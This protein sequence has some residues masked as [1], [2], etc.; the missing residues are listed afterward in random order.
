MSILNAGGV[1]LD[2]RNPLE[3]RYHKTILD[4][5]SGSIN[6]GKSAR[7]RED[8]F[9]ERGGGQRHGFACHNRAGA[10]E[11]SGV[12]WRLIGVRIDDVDIIGAGAQHGSSD[13]A[14]A[15]H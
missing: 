15:G 8:I 7:I 5:P 12:I 10:G 11:C 13:L 6:P 9:L 3:I 4:S 14:M 2:Q 1:K